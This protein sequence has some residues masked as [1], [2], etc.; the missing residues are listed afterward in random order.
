[1]V[2]QPHATQRPVWYLGSCLY[3]KFLKSLAHFFG[4]V[5]L[6]NSWKLSLEFYVVSYTGLRDAFLQISSLPYFSHTFQFSK[7][8]LVMP[9]AGKGSSLRVLG[10]HTED[11]K[12]SRQSGERKGKEITR[13]FFTF[14]G[15]HELLLLFPL[16]KETG[17]LCGFKYLYCS[18]HPRALLWLW[19]SLRQCWKKKNGGNKDIFLLLF[20]V[21]GAVLLVLWLKTGG[22]CYFRI[23][24]KARRQKETKS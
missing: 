17:H 3:S 19:L 22:F 12:S 23:W 10:F 2:W 14:F 16:A 11:F 21:Q 13:I 15:Q 18:H 9:L 8:F 6:I 24:V 7:P 4:S 20:Y 1:M 5:L